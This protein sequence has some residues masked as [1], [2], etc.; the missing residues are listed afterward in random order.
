MTASY[1]SQ[2]GFWHD[3]IVSVIRL[4]QP[5]PLIMMRCSLTAPNRAQPAARAQY[6]GGLYALRVDCQVF[7][8]VCTWFNSQ[9]FHDQCDMASTIRTLIASK[10]TIT[11]RIIG[12]LPHFEMQFIAIPRMFGNNIH[13]QCHAKPRGFGGMI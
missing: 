9:F 1:P 11:H 4:L 12:I 13:I 2:F 3:T 5:L 8:C 10:I 7:A 6:C